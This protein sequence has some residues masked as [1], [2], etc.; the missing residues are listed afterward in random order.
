MRTEFR[1]WEKR[2]LSH[3]NLDPLPRFD[4]PSRFPILLNDPP[5]SRVPKRFQILFSN[6]GNVFE[7]YVMSLPKKIVVLRKTRKK[8]GG[9]RGRDLFSFIQ[10][11]V[12]R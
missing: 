1:V 5:P 7:V 12:E 3:A 4:G 10:I 2:N 6:S 9:G 8:R 11:A